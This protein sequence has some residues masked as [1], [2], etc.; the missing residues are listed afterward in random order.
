[1]APRAAAW[2]TAARLCDCQPARDTLNTTAADFV[3][4][5]SGSLYRDVFS[6]RGLTPPAE[7]FTRHEVRIPEKKFSAV[8]WISGVSNERCNSG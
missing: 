1:M 4:T 3:F 7:S 8:A 2:S 5:V 6:E